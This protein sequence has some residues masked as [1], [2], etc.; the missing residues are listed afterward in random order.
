MHVHL[1]HAEHLAAWAMADV[2]M[3]PPPVDYV[4]WAEEN[5]VF[6]ERESQFAGPY[7]RT[8][9]GYFD[10][11]LR[12]FSPDDPCRFV[13]LAKSAQLGGTVLANVFVGGSLSMDPGD[14]LY[15]HPTTDNAARWSK[16]KLA[17]FIRGTKALA[18][19]F[20]LAVPRWRRS[21]CCTRSAAMAAAPS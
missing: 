1:A 19:L 16:M 17:P 12:A 18:V 9:F 11:I 5:I 7:N 2:L 4:R 6:S 15:V 3:P 21:R 14:I 8:L 13:S 20:R 10:E